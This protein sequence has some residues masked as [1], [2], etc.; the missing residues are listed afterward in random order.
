MMQMPEAFLP[1]WWSGSVV[2]LAGLVLSMVLIYLN[3]V[4]DVY[5][6]TNLRVIDIE[7]FFTILSE[8]HL[9]VEYKNMRDVKVKVGN[10]LERI[11]DIGDVFIETP[12]ENPDLILSQVDHPFVLQDQIATIRSH[13]DK[14]DAVTK[15]NN[16]KKTL[17]TWFSHVISKQEETT[18][19]RTTPNLRNMDLLSAMTC[20]QQHD[21]DVMVS[22]EAVDNSRI[23]PGCVIAQ[24]P[25]PG[26]I[27]E[28]GSK[29][30]VVLS[31][32]PITA[33]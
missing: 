2:V 11:L 29:V 31:R 10:I 5:I 28:K 4:D 1:Y 32:R 12:G 3:Y 8:E 30:A 17:A 24:N 26:T 33:R 22:G 20:A 25:P 19:S 16:E 13:K 15:E 21:L 14:V 9:E 23:P 7:R 18:K 6:L 27:M